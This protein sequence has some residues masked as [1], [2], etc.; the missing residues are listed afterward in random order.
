[1]R[2]PPQSAALLLGAFVALAALRPASPAVAESALSLPRP[3]TFGLIPA[4]TFDAAGRRV[5]EARLRIDELPNG[6]VLLLTES[7]IDGGAANRLTAELVPVDGGAHLRPLREESRTDLTAGHGMGSLRV[8]HAARVLRCTSA[9]GDVAEL[10]IP[11]GDR[12]ALAPMNLLFLPLV[13]GETQEIDF[14]IAMCRGGPRTVDARAKLVPVATGDEGAGRLVEVRY[15]LDFGP[16]LSAIVRPF[17]PRF[18]LWFD[19]AGEGDWMAHRMPLYSTGPTV[20][21]VRTGFSPDSLGL[22]R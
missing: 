10:A 9:E 16:A 19:R 18:S 8:D 15:E 14:Q 21:V 7:H 6:D 22:D 11:D 13:R 17:L 3:L 12:V 4:Q 20:M 1:V 2:R 5:G